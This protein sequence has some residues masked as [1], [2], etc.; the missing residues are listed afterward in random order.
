MANGDETKNTD[1]KIKIGDELEEIQLEQVIDAT[2]IPKCRGSRR[3]R[4]AEEDGTLEEDGSRGAEAEEA[5]SGG[6]GSGG[7]EPARRACCC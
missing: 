7:S 1:N 5:G 6:S 2:A 3:K 4:E